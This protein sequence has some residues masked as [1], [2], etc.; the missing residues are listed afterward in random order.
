MKNHHNLDLGI[1]FHIQKVEDKS[2]YVL[3]KFQLEETFP[4]CMA[5]QHKRRFQVKKDVDRRSTGNSYL[6]N[7]TQ[8]K[9]VIVKI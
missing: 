6:W 2:K 5:N 1:I 4:H 9:N 8:G 7:L 3:Y